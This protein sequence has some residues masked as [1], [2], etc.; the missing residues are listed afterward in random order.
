MRR[1]IDALETKLS[2]GAPGKEPHPENVGRL[3]L[4]LIVLFILGAIVLSSLLASTS[5]TPK[6]V[7]GEDELAPLVA[8]VT[9]EPE[10][11]RI[12]VEGSGAVRSQVDI[13]VVPQ[14]QGRVSWVN[15]SMRAGGAFE[16]DEVL[17]R[18][19]AKDYEL[20]VD[21]LRSQVASAKTS[22]QLELAEGQAAAREWDEINPGEPAPDLVARRPQIRDKRAAL[23]SAEAQLAT[24]QLNLDRTAYA[25]PF[26]GRVVTSKVERGQFLSPGQ[27]YGEVYSLD[28]LEVAVPLADRDLKW[29]QPLENIDAVIRTTYLGLEQSFNGT[30]TRVAAELDAQTRFATVIVSLDRSSETAQ[31]ATTSLVPGVFVSV[32]FLG[33]ELENVY[34]VPTAAVQENGRVWLIVDGRLKAARPEI[35]RTGPSLTLVRGLAPGTEILTSNLPGALEGMAVRTGNTAPPSA[36]PVAGG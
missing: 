4:G 32:T 36:G 7:G 6:T 28:G 18:I 16:K 15:P 35:V 17:F 21:R 31:A 14:V 30:A 3:Q 9:V 23:T 5:R 22:L 26:D 1:I 2:S 34:A 33:P 12:R 27:S 20:E 24:A 25:L 8:A 19:E 29:L 11:R 13:Q 10:T